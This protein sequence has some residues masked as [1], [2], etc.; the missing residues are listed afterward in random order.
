MTPSGQVVAVH[1]GGVSKSF[2]SARVLSH[3]DI[4]FFEGEVH[5]LIGENGAG[6]STTGKII[7]GHYSFDEGRL[8]IFGREVSRLTPREALQWGVAMIHQE[9][10]LVPA[11]TAAENVFLGI[12]ENVAGVLTGSESKRF[13][14]LDEQ[15]K[16][17]LDPET[18]VA[19]LRIADRQKVEIM[20]AIARNARVIIMDEP[21]SSL[22]ADEAERLHKII[23]VLRGAGR[24]V[25]YVTHFLDHVLAYC[26][27]VT[28]MRDGKVIRTAPVAGETKETLVEAMLGEP[29]DV[30][31]PQI[32][33]APPDTASPLLEVRDA[34]TRAGIRGVSIVVKAGEIVGL[35]GLVGSGRSETLRAI[36]GADRLLSGEIRI[37]D[38]LYANPTPHR[39]VR[40][41]LVMI[42]EE[43]RRQGLVMTQLVRANMSLPHLSSLNRFGILLEGEERKRT[44]HFIEHFDIVPPQV[45][46]AIALFSGGNQ[47]KVLL[48]KWVYN[49]P[50][51]VLLD[52]PTRGVD[53][54]ARRRIHQLVVELARAG[55]AVVLVSSELEE[56]IALSHRGYLLRRGEVIG[57]IECHAARVDDV[58]FRLFEANRT[59]PR[60]RPQAAI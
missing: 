47:Q 24:T 50:K 8:T 30:A 42:P 20:R 6:K 55:A 34:T 31:F 51:I 28:I 22:T 56:V 11:L 41:G 43:R 29:A 44:V 32:P 13:R 36:F 17:G 7:G 12:E 1:L 53:I 40:R 9:L 15:C 45:N 25:I 14:Q 39:S 27:R 57:Q 49:S 35:I 58:L 60:P 38:Q 18:R 10:Q 2:G 48:S 23:A 59:A 16:F 26:D 4:D 3:V 46:G 19:D 37:G 33:P 52:E 21:T 5:G 54:G